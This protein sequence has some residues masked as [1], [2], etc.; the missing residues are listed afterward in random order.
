[1]SL[2]IIAH[3][4][5]AELE[6]PDGTADYEVEVSVNRRKFIWTGAILG[7]VRKEGASKLLRLIA[8]A[9]DRH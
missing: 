5:G 1:M 4:I 8:D 6:K 7:H 2:I 9:M 3:N